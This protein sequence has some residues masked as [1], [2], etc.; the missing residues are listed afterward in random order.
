M[1]HTTHD[2]SEAQ[3]QKIFYK[4]YDLI[5]LIYCLNSMILRKQLIQIYHVM[6]NVDK[7]KIEFMIA[8]L[9][10][11]N[12]LL[13]KKIESSSKTKMLYL[14]KWPRSQFNQN[15][16]CK[17]MEIL[18][19]SKNK[20]LRHIF[21]L[22]FI[23]QTI[24]PILKT[25]NS[26][27]TTEQLMEY[28]DTIGTNL[29]LKSSPNDNPEFYKKFETNCSFFNIN[30]SDEFYRDYKISLYD[31]QYFKISHS[32]EKQMPKPCEEKNTRL[33]DMAKCKT[34][35]ER[36]KQFYSLN[37]FSGNNFV[38]TGYDQNIN[39]F[40]I[41]FFDHMNSIQTKKLWT[42]ICFI[43]CMFQRYMDINF[44]LHTDLFVWDSDRKVQLQKDFEKQAYDFY[45]Q[46]WSGET[47]V[48]KIMQDIGILPSHRENFTMDIKVNSIYENY[49][50]CLS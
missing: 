41:A 43:Y 38:Y 19:F 45:N 20:M 1:K 36:N 42:N 16:D 32:K 11:K 21:T 3:K 5:H 40:Y 27:V 17:D 24:M 14:S 13:Q 44:K 4:Y 34:D 31:K 39:T 29:L 23:L 49:N 9:I 10:S 18:T 12:F 48:N 50:I 30:L 37:N 25:Y 46:E 47:K 28:M 33:A 35:I 2:L 7:K 15:K 22:D 26:V 6:Y 8:E